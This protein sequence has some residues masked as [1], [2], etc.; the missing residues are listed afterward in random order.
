VTFANPLPPW[1][2]AAAAALAVLVA[3]AAYSRAPIARRRRG[4]LSTLR[5]VTLL[6]LVI[7]LMRPV[8]SGSPDDAAD[9]VVPILV[10]ASR[11]MGIEDVRQ[12]RRIDRAREILT[13]SL[14][15]ALSSRFQTDVLAFGEETR[16][17]EPSALGA[18]GRRSD[19]G[20]A[21][22]AVRDR[23]QGRPVA[24]IVILSDGGDTGH[25]GEEA[26][27]DGIPPVFAIP[28]GAAAVER[29]REVLSVTAAEA[30][31]DDS[32]VDLAVSAVSRGYGTAPVEI[33][34]L[35][36]GRP[37]EVRRVAPSA[38]GVPVSEIFKV[39]PAPGAATVYTI[40]VPAD[41]REI[42]PENNR[43]SVLVQPPAR[44]RR[45]L[46]VQG[47]P[48]FE[49]TF[50]RRAWNGDPG[51]EVDSVVRKGKNEQGSDT[52]YI[53]A[54]AARTASLVTGF[55]VETKDLFAY[56]AIV[57]AN[58]EGA[59]LTSAQLESTREFV[60]RRGGG[61]LV[62][63]AQSFTRRGLIDT[64]LEELLPLD[65]ADRGRGVLPAAA[66][67][68]RAAN[69]VALTPAGETHPIMQLTAAHDETRKR[70][71]AVPALAAI[72][73]LGGPRPGATVLAVTSGAGG[74]PRALVA[75]QRY[76]E[77]RSMI[78]T[79]EAAWR[80]RMMLPA[81]DRSYDTFWRQAVRWL[82]LPATDPVAIVA[83]A[84]AAA[85]DAVALRITARD[86]AFAPLR[87]A[88]VTVHVTR[89]D[90]RVE[91]I[92][93]VLDTGAG[94]TA[95]FVARLRA[96]DAGVYRTTAE[97]RAGGAEPI[98]AS[99][100]LLVGGA[101][102]EM[103]D[104]RVNLRVLQ[105]LAAATSGRII[106]PSET[107]ALTQALQSAVPAAV[108]RIRTDL[109]HTGWSFLAIVFLMAGEWVL[110]RR[111]GLR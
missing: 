95:T 45:V 81:S 102:P 25:S 13:G 22:A 48:G 30:V 32:R 85:G 58:V 101:D 99:T 61:L 109:W 12:A 98:A 17:V 23:Y 91:S 74:A 1:A 2:L 97:V 15:P 9:A 106:E 6:V 66:Q 34:L 73:A 82:A 80:W 107:G 111:W 103:A 49:G 63:G 33:R 26:D 53:Q 100:S 93:A 64:P 14:L 42:V 31:L 75:V 24:G 27:L 3:W 78:F 21:L 71:D 86:A 20:G 92:P 10:D 77:G 68:P 59:S 18:T 51:L 87:D 70:W 67:A 110:R 8:R 52:F 41:A 19:L 72:A 104:P 83:P 89:P 108:G 37:L 84:G 60:G 57:L 94:G 47:A 56:D 54:S 105:R 36:N 7:L 28:I 35:E 76:G 65:A 46:L 69:R 11:S 96:D 5:A 29:D 90:A 39:A 4:V 43:R 55:P 44:P 88:D 16:P 38:D 62:L 79:G 40:D 50:L